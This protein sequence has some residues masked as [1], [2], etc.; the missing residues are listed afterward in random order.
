MIYS[1]QELRAWWERMS[2]IDRRE[3]LD[4]I[5]SRASASSVRMAVSAARYCVEKETVP[6]ARVLQALRKW[7]R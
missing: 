6:E 4:L 5:D 7:E 2:K 1:D 3:L